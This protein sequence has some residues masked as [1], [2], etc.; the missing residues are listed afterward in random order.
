MSPRKINVTAHSRISLDA[1]ADQEFW[2]TFF[3]ASAADLRAAVTAAGSYLVSVEDYLENR[4]QG[5]AA[6]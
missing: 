5:G 6:T 2:C 4:R 3:D 1:A